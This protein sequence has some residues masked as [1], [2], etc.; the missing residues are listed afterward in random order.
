MKKNSVWAILALAVVA[1]A[2]PM[3]VELTGRSAELRRKAVD[4]MENCS[5]TNATS[6]ECTSLKANGIAYKPCNACNEFCGDPIACNEGDPVDWRLPAFK[7]NTP[8]HEVQVSWAWYCDDPDYWDTECPLDTVDVDKCQCCKLDVYVAGKTFH[9]TTSVWVP[10]AT[11]TPT[12]VP[13]Q[14]PTEIPTSI[15]TNTIAPTATNTPTETLTPTITPIPPVCECTTSDYCYDAIADFGGKQWNPCVACESMCVAKDKG[16]NL[17]PESLAKKYDCPSLGIQLNLGEYCQNPINFEHCGLDID[18]C[19]CCNLTGITGYFGNVGEC[20]S[21][22]CKYIPTPTFTP[23]PFPYC[24]P[25]PC[26]IGG[27]FS[28]PVDKAPC[29]GGCGMECLTPTPTE[30]PAECPVRCE[31]ED[32]NYEGMD[33]WG[34]DYNCDG[35]LTGGDFMIWRIE[36]LDKIVGDFLKSDGNCDGKVS[37]A[38]Y[39]KWREEYLK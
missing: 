32:E 21:A 8:G 31:M 37:L 17:A 12:E 13:T 7:C 2:L 24:T 3:A 15:P 30:T 36:F 33:K 19:L 10:G 9:C 18:P 11:L 22:I 38:D 23:T 27:K 28:C 26:P 20:T 25:V 4:F 14:V 1:V 6:A 16:E 34:G 5:C 39:S 35:S 29:L